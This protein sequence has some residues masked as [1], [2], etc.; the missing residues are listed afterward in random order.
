MK[1]MTH[2]QLIR[3]TYVVAKFKDPETAKL[4]NELA[5]RLDCALI[6]AIPNGWAKYVARNPE[7][8]DGV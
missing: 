3:A 1:D 5:G 8:D 2:E 4:L 7:D 6:K